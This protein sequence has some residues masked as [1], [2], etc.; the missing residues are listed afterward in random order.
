[1]GVMINFNRIYINSFSA[2]RKLENL[3]TTNLL[4]CLVRIGSERDPTLNGFAGDGAEPCRPSGG[5]LLSLHILVQIPQSEAQGVA[6]PIRTH[7]P[8]LTQL[9][10]TQPRLTTTALFL[11]LEFRGH[12]PT[13]T[14]PT[15]TRIV[16]KRNRN[17]ESRR[18]RHR[19]FRAHTTHQLTVTSHDPEPWTGTGQTQIDPDRENGSIGWVSA[20]SA[21]MEVAE[22]QKRRSQENNL[23]T[24]FP[25][26]ELSHS[27]SLHFGFFFSLFSIFVELCGNCGRWRIEQFNGVS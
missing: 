26:I 3:C 14:A 9:A 16:P 4:Q 6:T 24:R 27:L 23:Y 8:W 12:H 5:D 10:S 13:S 25:N 18:H 7:P 20:T 22:Q 1:M 21:P 2:K 19:L 11:L 15:R 17:I